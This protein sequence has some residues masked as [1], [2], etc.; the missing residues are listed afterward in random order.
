MAHG[1]RLALAAAMVL[2]EVAA[3]VVVTLVALCRTGDN[4]LRW[5]NA[6]TD[7]PV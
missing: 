3:V 1:E 5:P 2:S 6:V 4:G 7:G